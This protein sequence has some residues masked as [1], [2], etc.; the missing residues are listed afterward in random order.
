MKTTTKPTTVVTAVPA[1]D[2]DM[3]AELEAL[4]A[5]N[6]RLQKAVDAPRTGIT[7]KLGQEKGTVCVYGLARRPVALYASQ[8]KRL[9]ANLEVLTSFLEDPKNAAFFAAQQAKRDADKAADRANSN[10]LPPAQPLT[11]GKDK[12][13]RTVTVPVS[14]VPA[15]QATVDAQAF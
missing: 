9:L 4:R 3:R 7:V 10:P 15:S 11:V 12:Y 1:S 6:A 2:A 5:E 13:G 8:W 14:P